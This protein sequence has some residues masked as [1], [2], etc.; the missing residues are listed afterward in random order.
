MG[1]FERFEMLIGK[2]NVRKLHECKVA[3]FGI[4]GVGGHASEALARSGIGHIALIDNDIVS[5]SNINR[6]IIATHKTIGFDK[7]QVMKERLIEINPEVKVDAIKKF[8]LP[9]NA[10]EFDFASYDYIID[11]VD[12]ISAKIEICVQAQKA[13]IKVISAMGA[14]NKLCP[15]MLE[16]AD[17]KNTSVCPL[18]RIMRRELSRRGINF[19]KV[20]YSKEK[21]LKG[22]GKIPSSCAFVPSVMGLIIAGEVIKDLIK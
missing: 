4:G 10:Q 3:V 13:N 17:I 6:Q 8:F 16:V 19:L 12:T 15:E 18:A 14:G 11:A 7:V 1:Q 2:E 9:E 5:E 22:E 20:V 21:P